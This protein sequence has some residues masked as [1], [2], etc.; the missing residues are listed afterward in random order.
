MRE[1]ILVALTEVVDDETGVWERGE[2]E[3]KIMI[4]QLESFLK[5]EKEKGKDEAI[6][7]L[8]VLKNKIKEAWERIKEQ[9]DVDKG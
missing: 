2:V 3:Y 6:E 5:R 4:S 9:L 7:M 8:E 1:K